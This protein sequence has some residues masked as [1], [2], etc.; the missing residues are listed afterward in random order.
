MP[1]RSFTCDKALTDAVSAYAKKYKLSWSAAVNQLVAAALGLSP[2][3]IRHGGY[4]WSKCDNCGS[5]NVSEHDGQRIC[6]D[7]GWQAVES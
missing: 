2:V 3:S 6:A 7:C 5:R 4:R 1:Q